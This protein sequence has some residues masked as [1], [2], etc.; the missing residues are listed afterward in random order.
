[1]GRIGKLVIG[2]LLAILAGLGLAKVTEGVTTSEPDPEPEPDDDQ[3][4]DPVERLEARLRELTAQVETLDGGLKAQV[5]DA[6][7]TIQRD[8]EA[9]HRKLT[10]VVARLEDR[11]ENQ[12]PDPEPGHPP[13]D[14]DE[15]E[16]D[17]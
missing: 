1:M 11:T 10:D 2:L 9:A 16:P 8:Q 3:G 6:L 15:P 12:E 13:T 4:P 14:D 5:E 17:D 7:E